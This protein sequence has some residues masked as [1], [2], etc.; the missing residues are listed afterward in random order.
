MTLT[1]AEVRLR[2]GDR[3]ARCGRG[4]DLHVHHRRLRS[5]G[6]SGEASNLITLCPAC[7]RFIH[8]D[9]SGVHEGFRLITG[10]DEKTTP[11]MHHLWPSGPVVLDDDGGIRFWG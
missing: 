5:Q 4:G 8:M 9:P 11:L 7:H 1:L 3:C 2:D 6:G 10:M